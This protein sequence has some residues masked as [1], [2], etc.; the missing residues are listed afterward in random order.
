MATTTTLAFNEAPERPLRS[1]LR[2]SQRRQ[3]IRAFILV[4]PLLLF[5][6][7]TFA[8]PI[9][10]MLFASVHDDTLLSL[11]PRTMTALNGWDGM[12]LPGEAV[13]ASLAADLKESWS[14]RTAAAIGTRI[15]YE[16][17]GTQNQVTSSARKAS[18]LLVGQYKEALIEISPLWGRHELWNLLK[19]GT[20]KYTTFYLLRSIDHQ[21]SSDGRIVAS[22]PERA[23]YIDVFLRTLGI[24]VVV[25]AA[26]LALGFPLA[27]LLATLPQKTSSL[28]MI[29]VILPFWTSVLA[30]TLAWVILFQR[31]GIVNE[32]LMALNLTT[33]PAELIFNR[34]GTIVAMTH[35][36]LP[37]TLLPIYSVMKTISPSYVR[38]A[39]SLGAGPFYAFWKIYFPQTAAG[40]GAGCLLTFILSLGYYITPALV[41]G[42]KDQMIAYFVAHYTNEE[43]NWGMASALGSI[44]LIATLLLYFVFNKFAGVERIKMG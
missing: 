31:H 27:Y 28:L 36:Q 35:I 22:P 43:L 40:V 16:L 8:F 25:T 14:E 30:R 11:M 21:F 7:I 9:G 2:K 32:L 17:P 6:V 39:R 26:T 20:S 23:I 38:A 12:G 13:Y 18:A 1:I 10:R 4:M 44:L 19:R 41:G 34:F 5:I 33:T 24:S 42:P 3:K 37:V 15:N 29:L